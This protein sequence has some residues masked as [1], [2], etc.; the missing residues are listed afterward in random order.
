MSNRQAVIVVILAS[1]LGAARP[2]AAGETVP[3]VAVP[4]SPRALAPRAPTSSPAL[5]LA[6]IDP[7]RVAAAFDGLAREEASHLLGRM[8]V[9]AS[10]RRGAAGELA[11]PGE[12]RV[13]FLDRA[14][15]R[16]AGV[17][18]LGATPT[19]FADAPFV[20]VH[21]PSV[22]ASLGLPVA[23]PRP[24]MSAVEARA[25][26]I[27][28]GRVV[29]HEVVH[30]VAP[31]VPHGTGLM[32]ASLGRRQ[33]TAASI[34]LDPAV[35]LAVRTALL[36]DAPFPLPPTDVLAATAGGEEPVR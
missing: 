6:W 30:A 3:D 17:A 25:L 16:P 12:V 1:A 11:L 19:R 24:G 20:W 2:A 8:G 21:V 10:W 35:S 32:S 33:L 14:A 26:A 9:T 22:R 27:A 23:G 18:V 13:I 34:G 29:A 15:T 31:H 5:R 28:I 36:G 7:A 4:A